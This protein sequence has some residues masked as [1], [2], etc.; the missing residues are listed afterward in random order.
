MSADVDFMVKEIN[1]KLLGATIRNAVRTE[2]GESFGLELVIKAKGRGN[3]DVFTVW[4][5][6]DAEGNGPGW[7]NIEERNNG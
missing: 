7:L 2:D 6:C 5:D 4:I 3:Y 1:A